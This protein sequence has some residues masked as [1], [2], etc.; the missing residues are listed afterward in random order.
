MASA[1]Q[2]DP[3]SVRHKN[4]GMSA[5]QVPLSVRQ[6]ICGNSAKQVPLVSPYALEGA[7]ETSDA[8]QHAMHDPKESCAAQPSQ[9]GRGISGHPEMTG[10]GL[11]GQHAPS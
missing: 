10:K 4:C 9:A 11:L 5:K 1:A 3:L 8:N 2:S 6:R 7:M